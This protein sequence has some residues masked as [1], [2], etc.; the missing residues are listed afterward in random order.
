MKEYAIRLVKGQDLYNSIFEFCKKNNIEAGTVISG[1]GC[2]TTAK[3]RGADGKKIHTLTE[4]LEIVSL[5][6]TVSKHRLHIHISLAKEN[7]NVIGG[8]MV[9]GCLVN[10]T[11]EI[12][13][14]ELEKYKFNKFF[15]KN[16]GYNEILIEE[17][18]SNK[19]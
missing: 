15:D 14:V 17:N 1:V 6:G 7:L 2:L 5:M 19:K 13:I 11:C 3:I 9:E 10:T 16:T 8:H 4:P 12:V 18:I